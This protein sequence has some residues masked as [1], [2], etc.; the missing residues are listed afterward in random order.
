[1]V[2]ASIETRPGRRGIDKALVLHKEGLALAREGRSR[3]REGAERSASPR[4][5]VLPVDLQP[6]QRMPFH[7]TPLALGDT[8]TLRLAVRWTDEDGEHRAPYTLQV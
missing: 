7:I 1:L 2:T 3:G 5:E 8:P 4:L 6:D